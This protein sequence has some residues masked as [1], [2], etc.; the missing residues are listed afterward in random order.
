MTIYKKMNVQI[1]QKFT[2]KFRQQL[3]IILSGIKLKNK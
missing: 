1:K 3:N 2:V